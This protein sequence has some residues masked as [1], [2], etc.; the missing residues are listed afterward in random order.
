MG[1]IC[2]NYVILAIIPKILEL[3]FVILVRQEH[4]RNL[5]EKVLAVNVNL[6]N[7]KT[8]KGKVV[9]LYVN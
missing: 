6:E 2:A 9:V 5:M 8:K 7:I 4:I 1:K 3:L